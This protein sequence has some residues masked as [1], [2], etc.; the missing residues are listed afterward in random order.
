MQLPKPNFNGEMTLEATLKNQR[1]IRAFQSDPISSEFLGQMFWAA[2]GGTES[3][4][5]KRS[6]AWG[7]A[8]YPLDLY[9]LI[10]AGHVGRHIF[11]EAKALG[12]GSGIVGVFE[13]QRV[14]EILGI[15]Q[16]HEPLLIMPM[17]KKG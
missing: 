5:F 6:A 2:Y 12:L 1:I 10:E 17:G 11:S 3:D 14:I 8:L 15:P 9:A 16:A 4:G 7:G 13:D